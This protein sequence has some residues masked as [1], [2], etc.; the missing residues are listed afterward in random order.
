MSDR[1]C[2]CPDY[3]SRCEHRDGW[4]VWLIVRADMKAEYLRRGGVEGERCPKCGAQVFGQSEY[5]ALVTTP[6]VPSR[7]N[8][9]CRI[10]LDFV[11]FPDSP[12]LA[13]TPGEADVRFAEQVVALEQIT[14]P[15]VS[16]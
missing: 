15:G 8:C 12:I 7:P 10:E 11:A 4:A 9:I 14:T 6:G 5:Y 13:A 2:G 1:V 16:Q 3:V